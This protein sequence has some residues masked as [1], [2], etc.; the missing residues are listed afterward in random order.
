MRHKFY[1][2]ESW[3][4]SVGIVSDYRLETGV[5]F[6]AKDLSSSLCVQASSEAHPASCTMGTSNNFP[7]VKGGQGGDADHSHLVPRSRMSRTYTSSLPYRFNG[8]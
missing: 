4:S 6:P 2:Y 1:A 3:G 7:G 5:R 8:V